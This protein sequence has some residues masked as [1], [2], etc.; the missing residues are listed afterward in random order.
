MVRVAQQKLY[1]SSVTNVRPL[2]KRIGVQT[3]LSGIR[4]VQ[5]LQEGLKLTVL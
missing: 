5:T 3:P 4:R 2:L 1:A